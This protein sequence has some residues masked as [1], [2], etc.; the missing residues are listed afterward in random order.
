MIDYLAYYQYPA[1]KVSDQEKEKL[2]QIHVD[3][4]GYIYDI[5]K[6]PSSSKKPEYSKR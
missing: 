4:I 1:P 2:T 3:L 5:S 6:A